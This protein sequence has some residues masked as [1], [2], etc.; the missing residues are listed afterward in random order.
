MELG[1]VA[2]FAYL[3]YTLA[4]NTTAS[5]LVAVLAPAI[6][7]GLW[8]AIDFHQ[9]GRFAEP[10]RLIQELIISGLALAG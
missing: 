3:G 2:A 10:L 1:I 6:T 5:V 4:R 8:G 9:A 7:F